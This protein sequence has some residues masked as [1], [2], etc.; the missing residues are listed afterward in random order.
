MILTNAEN[1][2]A[3]HLLQ[4]FFAVHLLVEHFLMVDSI[5]LELM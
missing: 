3:E 4:L 2:I 1:F 5:K